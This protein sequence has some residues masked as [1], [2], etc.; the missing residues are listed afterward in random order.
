MDLCIPCGKRIGETE[1][2]EHINNIHLLKTNN[3]TCMCG[4]VF[5]LYHQLAIHFVQTH[6]KKIYLC[7]CKFEAND[8]EQA[9]AHINSCT[10]ESHENELGCGEEFEDDDTWFS[11]FF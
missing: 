9:M 11:S 7:P 4:S 3:N 2:I 8:L 5:Q 10:I 6:I 1:W